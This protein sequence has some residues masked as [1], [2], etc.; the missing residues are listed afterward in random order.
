MN[1]LTK[2]IIAIAAIAVSSLM[3]MGG[4]ATLDTINQ[5]EAVARSEINIA[6][7]AAIVQ[8]SDRAATAKGVVT[9]AEDAKRWIDVDGVS[10][11]DAAAKVRV[12]IAQS[13]MEL[14][15]KAVLNL[16]VDLAETKIDDAIKAGKLSADQLVTVNK[17]LDWV[18][19]SAQAYA[20]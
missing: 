5:N 7:L 20:G 1:T 18:I 14:S 2:K 10:I 12:R 6:T 11:K 17:L 4:C 15:R 3:L 8:S 19:Q 13:D 16:L 9:A